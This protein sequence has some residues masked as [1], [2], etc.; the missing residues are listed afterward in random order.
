MKD[1]ALFL[2]L[3]AYVVVVLFASVFTSCK[4]PEQR[5][6]I[7]EAVKQA[8]AADVESASAFSVDDWMR[9]HRDVAVRIE[10]MCQPL[11]ERAD[12]QWGDTTEGKVCTAARNSAS[13]TYRSPRDGKGYHAGNK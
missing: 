5:S 1:M 4:R 9:K 2:R 8:G 10:N 3:R 6:E 12:A 11:R 7:V 13:S